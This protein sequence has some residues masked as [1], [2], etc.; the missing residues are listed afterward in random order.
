MRDFTKEIK[1]Y[2]L[3][4][5]IEYGKCD[6]GKILPK[7]FQHGLEREN[8]KGV[9]PKINTIV[10]EVNSLS[11]EE[12]EKEFVEYKRYVKEREEKEKE[13]PEIDLNGVKK[14]ITRIAPE[15]SKYNH[16]GHA[17][18]FLINYLYAQKYGG[19]C[20]LR[21]ED[22]NPEKVSQEYVDGMLEDIKDYLKIK[23]DGIR[24]VS[25][26][27]RLLYEYAEKLI[28]KG[29]AYVCFCEREKMQD[30]R[31]KGIECEC[32]QF[33]QEIQMKRWKE[34]L[35]GDYSKG[36]RILR[37][38]GNMQSQNHVMRDPALFRKLD[39]KHYRHG[40]KYKVWPLYDFYNPIE[41]SVM[42][43]TLILRSNEFD[44]RVEL[45]DHIKNLLGLKEQKIIQ[46][47][48]FNVI[49]FTTR[50]RE[51]RELI[52]LGEFVGWDDP[53]LV[54][55]RALKK[56]G[57]TSEAI[58]ALVNQV[59][60]SKHQVNIDFN[61]IAAINR[62]IIDPIAQRYSFIKDPVQLKI[63]KKPDIK[64]IEVPIHP[65]KKEVRKI[66]VKDISI[67]KEDFENFKGKEVRLMHLYNIKLEKS[68][69]GAFISDQ[70]KDISKINWVSGNVKT[71]IFMSDATWVSGIAES[72]IKKLKKEE[73]IQFERFGFV[74][75]EGIKKGVYEF[76]FGHK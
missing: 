6:P 76:W 34:F 32:R 74:R 24:Y 16:L 42:G 31:H 11:K 54:T 8:I 71:K 30:L 66:K 69:T 2:A 60:L 40:S 37:L 62:K 33:S 29:E 67:S 43:I 23:I 49:D 55:L 14:I 39:A 68:N 9:I 53:R 56:R 21:F 3:R 15:P 1:A 48:R 38:K 41:D 65:D 47:G 20:L 36:D 63:T 57:I 18:T 28:K 25:D 27:M 73:I 70:L 64:E 13:L 5:S 44:M 58:Y 4:N 22:T 72:A 7:L 50:G 46:Y 35:K 10:E 75:F 51:I 17:L 26:D 59:G 52:E 12:R 45:Q 19:K 61:M